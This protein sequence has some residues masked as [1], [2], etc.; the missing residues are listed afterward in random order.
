MG[1]TS[2]PYYSP[3]PAV[4][5][6]IKYAWGQGLALPLPLLFPL[7]TAAN[8]CYC[9]FMAADN[10]GALYKLPAI[11]TH[12]ADGSVSRNDTHLL[13]LDEMRG[14]KYRDCDTFYRCLLLE[15]GK[16]FDIYTDVLLADGVRLS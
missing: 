16:T 10:I 4:D 12:N 5:Q 13:I 3:S 6:V 15:T 14:L 2:C 8:P 9:L 1:T 11:V 7:A